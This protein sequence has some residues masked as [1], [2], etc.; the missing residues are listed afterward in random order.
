MCVE[1]VIVNGEKAVERKNVAQ[2]VKVFGRIL[3]E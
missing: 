1:E 2:A 3:E